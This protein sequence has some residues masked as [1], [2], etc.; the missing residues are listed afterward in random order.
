M[1]SIYCKKLAVDVYL[2]QPAVR[3]T[4]DGPGPQQELA[5]CVFVYVGISLINKLTNWA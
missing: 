2:E 5:W 3:P 1:G 4:T